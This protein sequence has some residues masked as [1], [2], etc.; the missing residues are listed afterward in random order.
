MLRQDIGYRR[1][2]GSLNCLQACQTRKRS[3]IVGESIGGEDLAEKRK[4][5]VVDGERIG[6]DRLVDLFPS[7]ECIEQRKE[8]TDN[9][10]DIE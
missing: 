2:E 5:L 3:G 9:S 8:Q 6:M 4:I 1:S 7:R 10:E